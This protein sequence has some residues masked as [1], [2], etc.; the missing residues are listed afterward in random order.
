MLCV[1]FK[2][3]RKSFHVMLRPSFAYV[4]HRCKA[5]NLANFANYLIRKVA[6]LGEFWIEK[7][8]AQGVNSSGA[9]VS[10]LCNLTTHHA[11]KHQQHHKGIIFI[12]NLI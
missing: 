12:F 11:A 6:T 1:A 5:I 7:K 4:R 3:L 8:F 2:N 10:V 9:K